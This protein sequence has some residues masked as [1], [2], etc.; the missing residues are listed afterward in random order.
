MNKKVESIV[1]MTPPKNTKQVWA[2]VGIMNYYRYIWARQS[3]LLHPLTALTLPKVEF[4]WTDVEGKEFD[5]IKRTVAHDTLLA[6]PDINK[7]FEIHTYASNQHLGALII[8]EVK[9]IA[10]YRRKLT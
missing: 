5:E 10:F 8:Q 7:R 3:H 2:F 6:Y 1:N 9:P 4:K